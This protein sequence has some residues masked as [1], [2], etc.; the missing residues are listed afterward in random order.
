MTG[1]QGFLPILSAQ[2]E[3]LPG[4][5]SGA[6]E[7]TREAKGLAQA[8]LRHKLIKVILGPRRAGGQ[9]QYIF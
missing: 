9:G 7:V 4:F 6:L 3:E 8:S 2:K 1:Q 5:P